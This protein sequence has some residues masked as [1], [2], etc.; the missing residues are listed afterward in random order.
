MPDQKKNILFVDDEPDVLQAMK[1]MLRPLRS[2]WDMT[3]FSTGQ[4][5]LLHMEGHPTDVIVSDMRMPGMDG[6]Q[7]LTRVTESHPHVIR[8]VLSGQADRETVMR[9]VEPTHQYLSKPCQADKL[10]TT[11]SLSLI[12]I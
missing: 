10:K 9:A 8:I 1:R 11:V 5:A 2:E 3:F 7:L 12:H 4:D 6:M